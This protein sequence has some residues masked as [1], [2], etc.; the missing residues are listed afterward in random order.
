MLSYRKML[1]TLWTA[2][3]SNNSILTELTK[4]KT[5][6][7]LLLTIQKYIGIITL[8]NHVVC[9]NGIDNLMILGKID[10]KRGRG[11]S[12]NRFVD[13]MG[14]VTYLTVQKII[15]WSEDRSIFQNIE[16]I[17]IVWWLTVGSKCKH[18]VWFYSV[19]YL[20][21]ELHKSY[22]LFL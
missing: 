8:F 19:V 20:L 17:L 4:V 15:R 6:K 3:R 1:C 16:H 13:Q 9:K 11:Q 7:R 5:N 18:K 22:F 12:S 14:S 21:V 2:H 10:R